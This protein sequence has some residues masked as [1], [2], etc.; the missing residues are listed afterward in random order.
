[1]A[2][3]GYQ[4]LEMPGDEVLALG[5]VGMGRDRRLRRSYDL[6]IRW[7][8]EDGGWVD[9]KHKEE[10]KWTRSCPAVSHAAA[11]ALYHSR[12]P[13]YEE[14]LIRALNFQVWHLS[15]KDEHELQRVIYR[16][17]DMIKELV[18][19]TEKGVGLSS[20]PVRV[21]LDWFK[22]M[23]DSSDGHF[24]YRGKPISKHA[25]NEDKL[26]PYALKFKTYHLITDDWLTYYMAMIAKNL[27]DK[28]FEA[29][30]LR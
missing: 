22:G 1:M 29:K 5:K 24:T 26:T 10:R 19:F 14:P 3:A 23:Y 12:N 2:Q 16:G 25:W 27:L 7:Q 21:L 20:K 11:S 4:D 15:I 6:L 17:H 18:M 30:Q 8:R 9:E 13:R 28:P